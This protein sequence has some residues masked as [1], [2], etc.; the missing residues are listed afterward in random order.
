[1]E[2]DALCQMFDVEHRR[3][4]KVFPH[5]AQATLILGGWKRSSGRDCAKCYPSRLE[6]HFHA[7]VLDDLT[8]AQCLALVRHELAHLSDPDLGEAAT[9]TLAE[10]VTGQCIYYGELDDIQT[11]AG[12]VRPRPRR[13]PR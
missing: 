4:A 9:D 2:W 12:G 3:F 13:L 6:V 1:M 5:V 7:G 10:L 8:R 11:V